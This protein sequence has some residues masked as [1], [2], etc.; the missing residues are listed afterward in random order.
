MNFDEIYG[1]PIFKWLAETTGESTGIVT[2]AMAA[3]RCASLRDIEVTSHMLATIDSR[4]YPQGDPY[5]IPGTI[6]ADGLALWRTVDMQRRCSRVRLRVQ[7]PQASEQPQTQPCLIPTQW[8]SIA[9]VT[10]LALKP[11]YSGRSRPIP[12]LL[13]F[14]LLASPKH[15]QQWHCYVGWLV[16]CLY[17]EAFQQPGQSQCWKMIEN[18]NIFLCFPK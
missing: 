3:K 14:W 2:Q 5:G 10:F 7:R 18:S 6:S 15:L 8:T 1:C 16:P 17:Q 9:R 13:M 11:E 4:S 12:W